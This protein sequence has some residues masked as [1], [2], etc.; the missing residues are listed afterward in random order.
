MKLLITESQYK[1]IILESTSNGMLEYLNELKE[2]CQRAIKQTQEDLKINLNMLV[3]WGAGVAGFMGPLNEYIRTNNFEINEYQSSAI[4]CA[5]TAVLLNESS[6][7]IKKILHYIEEN[8]IKDVFFDVVRKGEKLKKAFIKFLSSLNLV[9]YKMTNILSYTFIIPILPMLWEL[10]N[11][12]F[13]ESVAKEIATRL[14]SF[15]ITGF[16]ANMIKNLISKLLERF[17]N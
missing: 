13:D 3:M 17:S 11:K 2:V 9:T 16:S 8:G 10:S 7:D 12:G 1:K 4:L 14:L 15:G 5:A 6:R